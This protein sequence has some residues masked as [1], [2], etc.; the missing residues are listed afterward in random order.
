M[1]LAP[2]YSKQFVEQRAGGYWIS[3]TRISLDSV[4]L[5]FKSGEDPETIV[6]HF[7]LLSLEQVYGA[8]SCYL[9]NLEVID[10]YLEDDEE[11]QT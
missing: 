7:P 8:I 3:G 10:L 11:D 4:I 1:T 2:V 9:S 5:P 6:R